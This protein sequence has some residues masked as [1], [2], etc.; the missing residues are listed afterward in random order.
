M[1]KPFLLTILMFWLLGCSACKIDCYSIKVT[2]AGSTIFNETYSTGYSKVFEFQSKDNDKMFVPSDYRI[3]EGKN[4]TIRAFNEK[5]SKDYIEYSYVRFV[6][7]LKY[8]R[9]YYLDIDKR[10]IDSEIKW[11]EANKDINLEGLEGCDNKEAYNCAKTNYYN[12]D[13]YSYS[14]IYY[15]NDDYFN[16]YLDSCE[17]SIERHSYIMV[18][19][20]SVI[21]YKAKWF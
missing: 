4:A 5:T 7:Y 19:E 8:E 21:T 12:F 6:G 1:K 2:Q 13:N 17:S 15:A 16:V 3:L 18:G 14:D 10:T 20:D 9:N 11:S